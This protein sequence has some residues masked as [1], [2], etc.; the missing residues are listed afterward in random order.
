MDSKEML[1]KRIALAKTADTIL[2]MVLEGSLNHLVSAY[3][4]AV[5]D[6]IRKQVLGDKT[7]RSFFWYPVSSLLKICRRLADDPK[8]GVTAEQVM[9]GCGQNAFSSM[10]YSPMGK[11]LAAFGKGNPQALVSNGPYAYT[12]A[13]SFGERVYARKGENAADVTFT[14]E[15]LGPAFTI[16]VYQVA[17]KLVSSV[18]AKVVATVNNESGTDFVVHSTW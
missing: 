9:A 18:D 13:V 11:M 2:G 1:D 4:A 17:F 14:R 6:P 7:I 10:L 5:V 3:G 16:A 12:L 15:L 8:L